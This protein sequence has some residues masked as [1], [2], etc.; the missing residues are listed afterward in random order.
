LKR[1]GKMDELVN[2]ATFLIS[3]GCPYINGDVISI[4]GGESIW[5][6]GQFSFLDMLTDQE[7]EAIKSL[8]K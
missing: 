6:S 8:R 1:Y 5:L 2:L 7:W 4:D 3:D